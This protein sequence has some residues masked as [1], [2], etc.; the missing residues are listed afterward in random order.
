MGVDG[1]WAFIL[2]CG[3]GRAVVLIDPSIQSSGSAASGL[4]D[5]THSHTDTQLYVECLLPHTFF[6]F[7]LSQSAG[8]MLCCAV[9][10]VTPFAQC[11]TWWGWIGL[12]FIN[13]L[14]FSYLSRISFLCDVCV[15]VCVCICNADDCEEMDE[16]FST[17]KGRKKMEKCLH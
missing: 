6:S 9:M 10:Y 1:L 2:L 12:L 5:Y 8:R 17:K 16:D 4:I 15:C 3:C 7:S 13:S 14:H 11:N